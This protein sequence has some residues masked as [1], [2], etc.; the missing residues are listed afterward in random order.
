MNDVEDQNILTSV[1]A[2]EQSL[3]TRDI[4]LLFRCIGT[5]LVEKDPIREITIK[6]INQKHVSLFLASLLKLTKK[7]PENTLLYLS[8]IKE[9]LLT[10]KI[11]ELK[12]FLK[13]N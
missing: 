13:L 12:V 10:N 3:K 5:E 1:V 9:L 7:Y 4:E 6:K 11:E 8:W 2:I